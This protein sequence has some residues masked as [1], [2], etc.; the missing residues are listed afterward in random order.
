MEEG[1]ESKTEYVKNLR[2]YVEY[3]DDIIIEPNS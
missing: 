1:Y 2:K 3:A